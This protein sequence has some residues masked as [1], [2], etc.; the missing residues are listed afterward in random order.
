[1]RWRCADTIAVQGL[2]ALCRPGLGNSRGPHPRA[3][4]E[5]DRATFERL[6]EEDY[7]RLFGRAV[8]G[9]ETEITVWSV[10]A[11]TPAQQPAPVKERKLETLAQH[12]GAR[13][14]FDP[15]QSATVIASIVDRSSL[16]TRSRH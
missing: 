8:A 10:N 12:S 16:T 2:H 5:P 7:T 13:D 15:A 11:T 6:F 3:G 14:L 9:M 1:M 4:V